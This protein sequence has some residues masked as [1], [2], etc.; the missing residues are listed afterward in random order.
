MHRFF[1][2][3]EGRRDFPARAYVRVDEIDP[4]DLESAD[5]VTMGLDAINADWDRFIQAG[6]FNLDKSED[7]IGKLKK[8]WSSRFNANRRQGPP[9]SIRADTHGD[10]FGDVPLYHIELKINKDHPWVRPLIQNRGLWFSVQLAAVGEIPVDV[11]G[12]LFQAPAQAFLTHPPKISPQSTQ[13]DAAFDMDDWPDATTDELEDA[14]SNPCDI[15][16]LVVFDI[17]QGSASALLCDCGRPTY[18]YD[19]G[20]GTLWNTATASA[21]IRF[22]TCNDPTIIL[23]HWDKDH[24]AGAAKWTPLQ[25]LTW[26]APRQSI[27]AKHSA[28]VSGM[29]AV[30]VNLLIVPYGAPPLKFGNRQTCDLRRAVGPSSDRNQSGL[31]LVVEDHG[32][33]RGWLM[34]GDVAYNNIANPRPSDLAAV[35]VPHHG[36]NMGAASIPP[37]ASGSRYERLLF[38]FGPGNSYGHPT[39]SAVIVHAAAGWAGGAWAVIPPPPGNTA[40]GL[41]ILATAEHTANHLNGV[42]VGWN[43][44]PTSLGHLGTCADAMPVTQS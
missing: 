7:E 16:Q 8:Y 32:T 23:S 10:A 9:N 43:A 21:S 6:L 1:I 18:Y 33:Q 19:V 22:C 44:P 39:T 12:G 3:N 40:A 27:G 4:P 20:C 41:P 36:A 14:L 25:R 30:G 2:P 42:R 5:I 35:I 26:V 31:V 37:P 28:F 24:W 15:A 17:G 38:S 29:L 11:Y 34:T 13:L